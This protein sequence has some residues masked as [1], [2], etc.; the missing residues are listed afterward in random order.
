MAHQIKGVAD[1]VLP[2][3]YENGVVKNTLIISPP[4]CGKTTLLRDIIRQISNGTVYGQ[5]VNVGVVDERSEIAGSYLGEPQN[6]VGIRTDVLDACPKVLG[7]MLLLRSMS[8]GVIAIDEIG[9]Q[10][11]LEALC[12]ASYC[13]TGIVATIHG[14]GLED[15]VKK[16][17]ACNP[18]IEQIFQC[19]L[20]LGKENGSPILHRVYG[21]EEI[22]AAFTGGN[23]D[24][25]RMS[26]NG[27]M[28]PGSL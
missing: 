8:P 16:I 13:G 5:G 1:K 19:A 24:S 6:D 9:G 3:L 10:E 21:E 26:G 25:G 2:Y 11:D 17:R 23:Y 7:M 22:N 27:V 28:V 14:N 12:Q 4:G 20:I 18:R 15:Y